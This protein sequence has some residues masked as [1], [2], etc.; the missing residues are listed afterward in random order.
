[1]IV[2]VAEN[3][4]AFRKGGFLLVFFRVVVLEG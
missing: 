3:G 2:G 1:M 4:V